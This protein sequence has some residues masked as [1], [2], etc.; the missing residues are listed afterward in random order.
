MAWQRA[1]ARL[2]STVRGLM[3]SLAPPARGSQQGFGHCQSYLCEDSGRDVCAQAV[4]DD[5]SGLVHQIVDDVGRPLDV[6]HEADT[7]PCQQVHRVEVAAGV[8][9]IP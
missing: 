9:G 2:Y 8:A 7:L 1:G 5:L 4:V 3:N 6:P